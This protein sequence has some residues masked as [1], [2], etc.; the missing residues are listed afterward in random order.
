[1]SDLDR[2]CAIVARVGELDAIA[3]DQDF[4]AAGIDSMR[5]MDIMLDLETEFEVT[6]P[7]D[8]FVKARTPTA[9]HELV[10]R[11]RAA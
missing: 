7:D 2:V 4:Y 6:I 10:G 3:P 8:Q 1:M 5:A 11:M 9:L